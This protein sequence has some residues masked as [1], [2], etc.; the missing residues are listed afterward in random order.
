MADKC[1]E[2]NKSVYAAEKQLVDGK[3]YHFLC[4]GKKAEREKKAPVFAV[5]EELHCNPGVFLH[6]FY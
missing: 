4:A 6:F 1:P 3:P 2:C 5:H